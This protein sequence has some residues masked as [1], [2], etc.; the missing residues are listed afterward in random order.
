MRT[1]LE[2]DVAFLVRQ[3]LSS[4]DGD[5]VASVRLASNVEVLLCVL[6]ELL[7]EEREQSVNILASSNGVAD[8][9]PLYE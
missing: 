8:G 6:R 3:D 4:K 7:E 9:R 2:V 5:V 1:D